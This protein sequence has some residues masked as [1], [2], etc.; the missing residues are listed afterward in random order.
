[1]RV[2]RLFSIILSVSMS[3]AL[4]PILDL[5]TALANDTMIYEWDFLYYTLFYLFSKPMHIPL[6]LSLLANITY[7]AKFNFSKY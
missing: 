4:M 5:S 6:F 7:F 1:M 3:I 2:K